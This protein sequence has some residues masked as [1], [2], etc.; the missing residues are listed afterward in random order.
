MSVLNVEFLRVF[1]ESKA[2]TALVQSVTTGT[3]N[4]AGFICGLCVDK[5]GVRKMG[6][7]GGLLAFLSASFFATSIPYLIVTIGVVTGFGF[8]LAF[9]SGMKSV[10]E[11]FSGKAKLIAIAFTGTGS[12]CGAITLPFLLDFLINAYGWRGCLLIMTGLVGNIICFFSVCESLSNHRQINAKTIRI[13]M[14][15]NS[16]SR[17]KQTTYQT[18]LKSLVR[19]CVF[20][21]FTFGISLTL[22]AF[23]SALVYLVEF[24]QTKGYERHEALLLYTY[25]SVSNTFGRLLPGMCT[26]I[27]Q[28]KVLAISVIFTSMSTFSTACLPSATMYYQHVFL[29]CVFGMTIGCNDTCMSM[30][31]ME[32]V[33][34]ENYAVGLG[35]LMTVAGLSCICAGTVFGWLVDVTGSYGASYYSVA[36]A[37][38]T[39]LC[40]FIL[41]AVLQ[42]SQRRRVSSIDKLP[43]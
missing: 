42:K 9:V 34:L 29:V 27:P 11:Y 22:S 21:M 40:L 38:A 43:A 35:I 20:I 24:L 3:L 14:T 31:T 28:M 19:N 1:G 2:K 10:G 5:Y 7:C 12:T 26:L 30:T 8:S 16:G 41:A 15:G 18:K 32:L 6:M 4:I 36:A 33:G 23:G 39:A 25:M 17:N 13:Y 37:H